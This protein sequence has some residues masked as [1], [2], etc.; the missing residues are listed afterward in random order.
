MLIRSLL[1]LLGLA[2]WIVILGWLAI[3][4]YLLDHK[5]DLD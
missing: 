2:T 4:A 1:I 3:L 5:K